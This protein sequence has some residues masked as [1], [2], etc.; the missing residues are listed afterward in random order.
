LL[1][2]SIVLFIN[3]IIKNSHFVVGD[4]QQYYKKIR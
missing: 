3:F 2:S 4:V 1:S